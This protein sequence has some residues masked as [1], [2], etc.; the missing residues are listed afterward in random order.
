[1]P[2]A[3]GGLKIDDVIEFSVHFPK[4]RT[5]EKDTNKANRFFLII[6]FLFLN[7]L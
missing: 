3:T 4:K 5:K 1:V 6:G 7:F 2:S